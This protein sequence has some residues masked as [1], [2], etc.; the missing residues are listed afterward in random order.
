MTKKSKK[1]VKQLQLDT[2]DY[3]RALEMMKIGDDS[4]SPISSGY[5][6]A[7]E[8]FEDEIPTIPAIPENY[9]LQIIQYQKGIK[10]NQPIYNKKDI[11]CEIHNKCFYPKCENERSMYNNAISNYCENHYK[12]CS[13]LNWTYKKSCEF[14]D[15]R[16]E[17][18]SKQNTMKQN[19]FIRSDA[20]NCIKSRQD[21]ALKCVKV[22]IKDLENHLG[23]SHN[24]RIEQMKK[25]KD[26]CDKII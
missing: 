17:K 7:N 13:R 26:E 24:D 19:Y 10:C 8:Y 1:K 4:P 16:N 11:F 22:A 18:C 15:K 6:T 21:H 9:C 20:I 25:I 5:E 2:T 12:T 23:Y 14:Y 3:R